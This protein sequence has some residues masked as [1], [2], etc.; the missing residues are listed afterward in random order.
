[1][2]RDLPPLNIGEDYV[3]CDVDSLITNISLKETIDYILEETCFNRKI[4]LSIA[5]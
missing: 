5:S 1:M 3:S 2:L 4:H